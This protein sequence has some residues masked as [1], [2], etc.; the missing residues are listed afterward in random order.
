MLF[1]DKML[2]IRPEPLRAR[3]IGVLQVN[4][5]YRCNMACKHCHVE[6]GPGRVEV[7][8]GATIEAVLEVL[9]GNDIRTLDITGGAPE[10]HSQFRSLVT[11]GKDI[12]RHVIVRSNLSIFFEHGMDDLPAFYRAHGVEVIASLPYYEEASVDRVRGKGAFQKSIEALQRLNSL[13]YGNSGEGL[14]LNL[15]H[16]PQGAFLPPAEISLEREYRRELDKRFGITFNH[17]YTFTN[18]PIGRFRDFLTRTHSLEKYMEK[19][20]RAF[21]PETLEGLMCRHMITVGWDGK[22]YDCDF[23]QSLGIT[24]STERHRIKDF[25]YRQLCEREI[26]VDDLCYGCTAGQGST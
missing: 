7:M 20:R 12:G 25:N 16:N 26:A 1:R 18:M 9:V 10:L 15:V 21:N 17:L 19:L 22:L 24:V 2:S 4:L 6:A 14:T 23:H 8:E 3:T 11:R 5:G 13:G